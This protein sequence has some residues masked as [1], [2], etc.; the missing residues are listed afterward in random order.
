MKSHECIEKILVLRQKENNF[1]F[2]FYRMNNLKFLPYKRSIK[3]PVIVRE[4]DTE[5]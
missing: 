4:N 2:M 1:L 5:K 3:F